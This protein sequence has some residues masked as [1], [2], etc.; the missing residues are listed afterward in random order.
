MRRPLSL[1]ARLTAAYAGFAFVLALGSVVALDLA[2]A[3]G[4]ERD[5][6]RIASDEARTLE[7]A[8]GEQ[9]F[10]RA[11]ADAVRRQERTDPP[12]VLLR[13]RAAD[14]RILAESAAMAEELPAE[15]PPVLADARGSQ[16][17]ASG[18]WW[19]V[20]R[21]AA[22]RGDESFLLEIAIERRDLERLL[23]KYRAG[24]AG[25]LLGALVVSAALSYFIARR[26][27]RPIERVI[28]AARRV[29]SRTL[30]AERLDVRGAPGE[31]AELAETFNAML[32]RLD[33]T[34][35]RLKEVG[36]DL[37]HELRTPVQSLRGEAEVALLKERSP[38]EY[39]EA[40]AGVLE[41]CGRL[42]RV[43]DDILLI[44]RTEGRPDALALERFDLADEIED[45][46]SFFEAKASGRGVAL[47]SRAAGGLELTADRLKV[48][49]ALANLID[50]AIE[51]TGA[52]GRVTVAARALDADGALE[53]AVEDTGAGI[54]KEDLARCF[55][56]FFRVDR[57][58]AR[59]ASGGV[60]LGLAIVRTLVRAHGG[61]VALESEVGRGTRAVVRIPRRPSGGSAR[62]DRGA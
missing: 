47:E 4:L 37:A 9:D 29:S 11:I 53:V 17:S 23:A 3:A 26:G 62:P 25:V 14:G 27:I 36:A 58:R 42:S 56:R 6:D 8:L 31:I 24:A 57:S 13:V 48:R 44:E 40:L 16:V 1:A 5:L 43:I 7:A 61:E 46:A 50:N 35:R 59:G 21:R 54:A 15:G 2:L 55:E 30:A 49:R 39:R 60:G 32:E 18:A 38:E 41:A 10:R 22:R 51:Y 19:Q 33:E 45:L 34:F 12:R 20:R 52:G 28:A